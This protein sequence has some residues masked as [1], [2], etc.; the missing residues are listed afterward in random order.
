MGI[1]KYVYIH[2]L[3]IYIYILYI[4]DIYMYNYTSSCL[5]LVKILSFDP[6]I[7]Q[8]LILECHSETKMTIFHQG[9]V[10]VHQISFGFHHF[11]RGRPTK[12][13]IHIC[14]DATK[15]KLCSFL[16]VRSFTWS[17]FFRLWIR[18]TPNKIMV[19]RLGV[20]WVTK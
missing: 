5:C 9:L 10:I 16:A 14:P 8:S 19:F 15:K 13:P 3:C 1:N 18:A 20:Y 6:K 4:I 11:I 12:W 17:S 7:D 2:I